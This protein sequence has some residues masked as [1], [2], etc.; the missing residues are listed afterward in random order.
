LPGICHPKTVSISQQLCLQL[1]ASCRPKLEM[2]PAA[3]NGRSRTGCPARHRKVGPPGP[4]AVAGGEAQA[5]TRMRGDRNHPQMPPW[6][7][8]DKTHS[9]HS[10]SK[11]RA[12]RG[13]SGGSS[14]TRL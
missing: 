2:R 7:A 12:K 6:A 4:T 9:R 5:Q 3:R 11:D 14:R 10:I 1:S 13:K 8:G